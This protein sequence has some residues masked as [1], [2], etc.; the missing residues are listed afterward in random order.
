MKINPASQRDLPMRALRSRDREG[1]GT[2]LT[3]SICPAMD[4]LAH[5]LFNTSE[6][7]YLR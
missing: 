6:F 3:P 7:L 2:S 5:V 1:A 4:R